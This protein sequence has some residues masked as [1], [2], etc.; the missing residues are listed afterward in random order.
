MINDKVN[1]RYNGGMNI[2]I[3][4]A[5][6]AG[7]STLVRLLKQQIPRLNVISFEAVRNAFM[8]AQ[9]ELAMDDRDSDARRR[10]LPEFL[11]EFATWNSKMTG[12]CSVVEGTFAKAEIV[13]SLINDGDLLV[14]LGY[15]GRDLATVAKIAIAKADAQSYLYG[16][17]EEEFM[18]H[19]YDLVDD[20]Q[21]NMEFCQ[22]NQ[23]LYYDTAEVREEVL[24]QVVELIKSRLAAFITEA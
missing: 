21:A 5:P 1:V 16:K 19:F 6:T 17:T 4:G 14:C 20:D 13:A 24:Q 7:K 11:V 2:Y 8:R 12:D 15:G 23:L 9:P 10:I 3:V 18:Q 22:K